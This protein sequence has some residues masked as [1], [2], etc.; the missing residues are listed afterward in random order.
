MPKRSRKLRQAA[1]ARRL[2]LDCRKRQRVS[3]S[4]E[5]ASRRSSAEPERTV[6]PVT[7]PSSSLSAPSTSTAEFPAETHT[8]PPA[9]TLRPFC[10]LVPILR[11][12]SR[13]PLHQLTPLRLFCVLVSILRLMSR[14]V[15]RPPMPLKQSHLQL[16]MTLQ[17]HLHAPLHNH[18]SIR[19][20][21]GSSSGPR[22]QEV[23]NRIS[24]LLSGDLV[25]F[26]RNKSCRVRF[27]HHWQER[28]HDSTVET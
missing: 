15:L 9:N 7:S 25:V 17:S 8:T 10:T 6:V 24:V 27:H 21:M 1:E 14:P 4:R 19:Q 13:S 22:Q 3:D 23:L 12:I 26:Y 28:P 18:G 2:S 11:L 5:C 16:P 20:R